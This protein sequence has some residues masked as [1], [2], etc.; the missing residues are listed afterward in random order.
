MMAGKGCS[1]KMKTMENCAAKGMPKGTANN[2]MAGA[3]GSKKGK[4]K[5]MIKEKKRGK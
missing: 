4:G 2:K 1:G 5:G 3:G